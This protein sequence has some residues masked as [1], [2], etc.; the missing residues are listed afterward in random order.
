MINRLSQSVFSNPINTQVV[1]LFGRQK[2][3]DEYKS[4]VQTNLMNS[5]LD[6]DAFLL[7]Q[8]LNDTETPLSKADR[9]M[10]KRA[11][12]EKLSLFI[13]KG[14]LGQFFP[15]IKAFNKELR[16]ILVKAGKI[17]K[18]VT[19]LSPRSYKLD[20]KHQSMSVEEAKYR[21]SDLRKAVIEV[22]NSQG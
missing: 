4:F 22:V 20:E 8:K 10:G 17:P 15:G 6:R 9:Q 18:F 13:G 19:W 3:V 5:T 12:H 16:Q 21:L 7:I 2:Y 14:D 1:P 11:P